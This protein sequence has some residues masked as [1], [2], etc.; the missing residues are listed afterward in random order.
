VTFEEYLVSKKINGLAFQQAD[1]ERFAEWAS[2]FV[3]MSPA[4]FTA[5]KLY[6]INSIRRKCP[7]EKVQPAPSKPE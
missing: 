1:P 7:L 2:E 4:S 3:Q 6:F 5:Q